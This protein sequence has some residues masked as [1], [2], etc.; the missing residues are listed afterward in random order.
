M[1]ETYKTTIDGNKYEVPIINRIESESNYLEKIRNHFRDK[2]V[3]ILDA[4]QDQLTHKAYYLAKEIEKMGIKTVFFA[5]DKTGLSEENI[6]KDNLTAKKIVFNPIKNAMNFIKLIKKF[7]PIHIELYLDMMPWD[8]MFIVFYARLKKISIISRCRGGE[9]L[10]WN[11]HRRIFRL[12]FRYTLR[13]SDL[14]LIR[15][16]YMVNNIVKY[17][18]CSMT[19]V[20]FFHNHTPVPLKYEKEN[21]NEILYLNSLKE[22]RHPTLMIDVALELIRRE[23]NFKFIVV[24]FTDGYMTAFNANVEEEKFIKLIKKNNLESYFELHNFS[25]K[26]T[27]YFRR[28]SIFILPA[29]IVFCN[30]SL[31]EAM[32]YQNVPITQNVEGADLIVED[33]VSGYLVE[34]NP[35]YYAERIDYLF[36]NKDKLTK[37]GINAR[38]NISKNYDSNKQAQTIIEY[39]AKNLWNLKDI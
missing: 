24:G 3:W 28:A 36:N 22:F 32:A 14:I 13:R 8:L 12:A 23:I 7:K 17:N 10:N 1:I 20:R 31:L 37:M 6:Q 2:E 25:N 38:A 18:I 21:N 16:L 30:H 29:D 15:E 33:G 26:T 39:Y 35:I 11:E 19:N 9:I 27:E 4:G 5:A 34:N